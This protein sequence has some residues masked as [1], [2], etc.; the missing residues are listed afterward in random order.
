MGI[1]YKTEKHKGIPVFEV[2]GRISGEDALKIS[3]KL[4]DFVREPFYEIIL[5]LGSIDFI[6]SNW[7]G[8]FAYC[9]RIYRERKKRLIFV[10]KS[11]FVRGLLL[12]SNIDRLATIVNSFDAI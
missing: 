11:E 7:L 8:I 4:E 12:N 1:V 5:D 6:D 3:R 2:E 9:I 10:V